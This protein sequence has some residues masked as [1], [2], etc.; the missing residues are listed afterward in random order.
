MIVFKE[1]N[2]TEKAHYFAARAAASLVYLEGGFILRIGV[3]AK[4]V[5]NPSKHDF[6]ECGG[7]NGDISEIAI[8]LIS[9]LAA[10]LVAAHTQFIFTEHE[11][12]S[13][14]RALAIQ[15]D[16]L[17][18]SFPIYGHSKTH[19]IMH[20]AEVKSIHMYETIWTAIQQLADAV[21]QFDKLDRQEATSIV[22]YALQGKDIPNCALSWL[23]HCDW[24]GSV[25]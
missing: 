20:D 19:K 23:L 18:T 14:A 15:L 7:L 5:S 10:S 11:D 12:Y 21:L 8:T 4:T 13:K 22:K 1:Y 16:S 6:C 9:G 3:N 24:L 25:D 2:I 17:L